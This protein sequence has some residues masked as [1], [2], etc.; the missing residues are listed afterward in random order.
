MPKVTFFNFC[1]NCKTREISRSFLN[2]KETLRTAN[3]YLKHHCFNNWTILL[4]FTPITSFEEIR[5]I[6]FW[7]GRNGLI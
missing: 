3:F 6:E 1:Q 2:K 4:L 5:E 7:A